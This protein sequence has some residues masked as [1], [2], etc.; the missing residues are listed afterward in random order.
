VA[1]TKI[2]NITLELG[3]ITTEQVLPVSSF[4]R[5]WLVTVLGEIPDRTAALA[6]L[7]RVLKPGG[8]LSITE[9]FVDPHYQHRSLVI[10]LARMAGFEPTEYWGSW[11]AFTQNFIKT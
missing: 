10:R 4:D 2:T 7:F 6:N 8:T 11:L 9:I 1:N 5:A 3:D